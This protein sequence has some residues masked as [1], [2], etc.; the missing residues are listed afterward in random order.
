MKRRF[1]T[2]GRW[3]AAFCTVVGLTLFQS[4][5]TQA[6][7]LLF[8]QDFS[9]V[10]SESD[11]LN[12]TPSNGQVDAKTF[13]NAGSPSA[14]AV[15][16]FS[17]GDLRVN[18]AGQ[19]NRR[20]AYLR[21]TNIAPSAPAFLVVS[22]DIARIDNATNNRD[23][24]FRVQVGSAFTN[25]TNN[26]GTIAM[27]AQFDMNSSGLRCRTNT[28]SGVFSSGSI[29][30]IGNKTGATA[31]IITP[32]GAL[33]TFNNHQYAVYLDGVRVGNVQS[34]SNARDYQ[35]IKF[36]QN[37][38]NS[39][40]ANLHIGLDNIKASWF[41]AAT[42]APVGS[43]LQGATDKPIN[44]AQVWNG[45]GSSQTISG[46]KLTNKS[47]VA[48]NATKAEIKKSTASTLA[49]LLLDTPV[50]FGS[51]S[52]PTAAEYEITGSQTLDAGVNNYWIY[53]D[54]SGSATVGNV[55]ANN[56]EDIQVDSYYGNNGGRLSNNAGNGA[57]VAVP[58]SGTYT[59]CPSGCD[60]TSL[61]ATGQA[62]DLLN[63][64]GA[65]GAVTF[66]YQ[67]DVTEP[68]Q[69][70]LENSSTGV[71]ITKS[72]AGQA[73]ITISGVTAAAPQAG[74]KFVNCS[75]ITIDGV[76]TAAA[77]HNDRNNKRLRFFRTS[78]ANAPTF[79]FVEQCNNIII[80]NA[81]FEG[82]GAAANGNEHTF[83]FDSPN[84]SGSGF[85]N[86]TIQNNFIGPN[87]SGRARS[88]VLMANAGAANPGV[89]NENLII[90]NNAIYNFGV[91]S[92]QVGAIQV[93]VEGGTFSG[94]SFYQTTSFSPTGNSTPCPFILAGTGAPANYN[95]KD[96]DITNNFIGGNNIGAVTSNGLWV[97]SNS[98]GNGFTNLRL[99][100]GDNNFGS[101]PNHSNIK[102]NNNT[103]RAIDISWAWNNCGS[104][105][106]VLETWVQWDGEVKNNLFKDITIRR[107]VLTAD[108]PP[109]S[110][111]LLNLNGGNNNVLQIEGNTFEDISLLSTNNG[112]SVAYT[113]CV[114][115]QVTGGTRD[116]VNIK[117]NIIRNINTGLLQAPGGTRVFFNGIRIN[118]TTFTTGLNIEGNQIYNIGISPTTTASSCAGLPASDELVGIHMIN[119][120]SSPVTVANNKVYNLTSSTASLNIGGIALNSTGYSG[121]MQVY[122]NAVGLG[123]GVSTDNAI[124]AF[125]VIGIGLNGTVLA[126]LNSFA[127]DGPAG[128]TQTF[129]GILGSLSTDIRLVNN[130]FQN[131]R[132]SSAGGYALY[133]GIDFASM[134]NYSS[135]RNA[136]FST[137]TNKFHYNGANYSSLAA[138]Q[139][140]TSTETTGSAFVNAKFID[141]TNG[142]FG[143]SNCSALPVATAAPGA[144]FTSV[145]TDLDGDPRTPTITPGALQF[146]PSGGG[147]LRIWIGTN[148]N[149]NDINNWCPAGAGV[150]NASNDVVI[151]DSESPSAWPTLAGNTTVK[152]LTIAGA[153][154]NFTIN[155]GVTLT[156]SENYSFSADTANMNFTGSVIRMNSASTQ[157]INGGFAHGFT[158]EGGGTKAINGK[159]SVVGP[160]TVNAG[161]ILSIGG[162]SSAILQGNING[163]GEVEGSATGD[164]YVGG[165]AN[166][167]IAIRDG[168]I[169]RN[170]TLN[171]GA[172]GGMTFPSGSATIQNVNIQQ[173]TVSLNSVNLSVTGN[174]TKTGGTVNPGS[175]NVN[176]N[177]AANQTI[178]GTNTFHN[179]TVTR[180]TDAD[181]FLTGAGG[182]TTV[183]NN[184]TISV[185]AS[186]ILSETVDIS[187]GSNH[188]LALNGGFIGAGS[189]GNDRKKL[190][191]TSTS[192]IILTGTAQWPWSGGPTALGGAQ[193]TTL[194]AVTFNSSAT[195]TLQGNLTTNG[196]LS[197]LA[198]TVN[199]GN[200]TITANSTVASSPSCNVVMSTGSSFVV[201]GGGAY[202]QPNFG[203]AP[204]FKNLDLIRTVANFNVDGKNW[205]LNRLQKPGGTLDFG[206]QT[207]TF[208]R[209]EATS[210]IVGNANVLTTGTIVF[211]GVGAQ[212]FEANILV[213]LENLIVNTTGAGLTLKSGTLFTLAN[214]LT[215]GNNA[216]LNTNGS[217]RLLSNSTTQSRVAALGSGAQINGDVNVR[218]HFNDFSS[219]GWF[220]LGA[221]TKGNTMNNFRLPFA[222]GGLTN[223]PNPNNQGNPT[224]FSYNQ[225]SVGWTPVTDVNT[226]FTPGQGF[227]IFLPATFTGSA[228]WTGNLVVGDGV[229]QTAGAGETF[230]FGTTYSVSG[231]DGGGWNFLSNPYPSTI[232]WDGNA[233]NWPNVTSANVARTVYLWDAAAASYKVWNWNTAVGTHGSGRI[234]MGQGFFVKLY[235]AVSLGLRESAK[236]ATNQPLTRSG[237]AENALTIKVGSDRETY[238]DE[239]ILNLQPEATNTFDA[240][241][242]SEKLAG[243]MMDMFLSMPNTPALSVNAI[244]APT[245]RV[246]MPL[247]YRLNN[248]VNGNEFKFNFSGIETFRNSNVKVYLQDNLLGTVREI[249]EDMAYYFEHV[250]GRNEW[251]RN[252]FEIV[253]APATVSGIEKGVG[254][255]LSMN[256]YPNP[257]STGA[258]VNIALANVKA[259]AVAD[260]TIVDGVGREVSRMAVNVFAG[261]SQH[262]LGAALP[263]GIYTIQV[264]VEGQQ[265]TQ[266]LVVK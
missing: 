109:H 84:L 126:Q 167:S 66:D 189:T 166:T 7:S 193:P 28:N 221:I 83:T 77:D 197:F 36:V 217:L 190:L 127:V 149:W 212:V 170:V 88:A 96:L 164:L 256:V 98:G 253:T 179:L 31:S 4:H 41:Y 263:A 151:D 199:V 134:D 71:T 72:T 115:I 80:R 51:Q 229:D 34:G 226:A 1:T 103:I 261:L 147:S 110:V 119:L 177:S 60:F 53:N 258:N 236:V 218:R 16:D 19:A 44:Y 33:T 35:Q 245:S 239:V 158:A 211:S 163:T 234:A 24:I 168:A 243:G 237:M 196:T 157:A 132:T 130:I 259:D 264:K 64:V 240:E 247:V 183:N 191:A 94:N 184:L 203:A 74:F 207:M 155:S 62:F 231:P 255:N 86:I 165:N 233:T 5:H 42:N 208:A 118:G 225:A 97:A 202:T 128:A 26:E 182:T 23:N 210:G 219:K 223:S 56:I 265:L 156:I 50:S 201:D 206:S 68:G 113:E 11:W 213:A 172:L 123:T 215:L 194:S 49:A 14:P 46:F 260:V 120:G 214:T 195:H 246:N 90:S 227:R 232:N 82:R 48:A 241:Y 111:R 124:S 159:L 249:T 15:V 95:C 222:M 114:P 266:K 37:D 176:F 92:G 185:S 209:Q 162:N 91:V 12:A 112:S 108:P 160:L 129:A 135:N 169:F 146:D 65:S 174:W 102:F 143:L 85:D 70:A 27:Q 205:T 76:T 122:N 29:V 117:N 152:S 228:S 40:T 216:V 58:F 45:S 136:L 180:L 131:T 38:N 116:L 200:N 242:D 220:F 54:V 133:N 18:K 101:G 107:I 22:F 87:G 257:A 47:T 244:P 52:S 181:L 99:V 178:S 17:N 230:N 39:A 89:I 106:G 2:L 100:R 224:V 125:A 75:N 73:T 93:T 61:T 69:V 63:G 173:G 187:V 43:V 6:Q 252:R 188:T 30:M 144:P 139:T 150:P 32:D 9:S 235:G 250:G 186:F 78:N 105:E 254:T 192:G 248:A 10:S 198:G 59:I 121:T 204:N 171:R 57:V 154:T 67:G 21:S 141:L 55:I 137:S 251:T 81:F 153:T 262:Q 161:T 3:A 8:N 238:N 140:A 142:N 148:S 25:N 79:R 20:W 138:Y 175:S 145:T 13:A 104:N